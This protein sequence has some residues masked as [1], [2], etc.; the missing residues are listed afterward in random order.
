VSA[1]VTA[2]G[3]EVRLRVPTGPTPDAGVDPGPV[4]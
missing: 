3:T 2:D 1:E 4:E